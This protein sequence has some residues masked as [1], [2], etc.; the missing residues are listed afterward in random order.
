MAWPNSHA[1]AHNLSSFFFFHD[2]LLTRLH[3]WLFNYYTWNIWDW[4]PV[5]QI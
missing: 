2:D 3:Q 1:D 4:P 5:Q